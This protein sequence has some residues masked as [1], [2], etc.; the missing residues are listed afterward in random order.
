MLKYSAEDLKKHMEYLFKEGMSW[1]NW[2]EWHIDHR[3]PVSKFDPNTP[4]D[5]VNS[6]DNLQPLWAK[7]NL[8][9]SNKIV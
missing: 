9:K 1:E 4:I 6:L 2:G 3:I 8:S 5:I 7:D